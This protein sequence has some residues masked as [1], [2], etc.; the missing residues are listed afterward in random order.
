MISSL[1]PRRD[2]AVSVPVAAVL[3]A[4]AAGAL[5]ALAACGGSEEG[6]GKGPAGPAGNG[7]AGPAGKGSGPGGAMPPLPVT[8]QKMEPQRVPIVLEAVGQAE[9]S[10]EVEVRARVSGILEKRAY[11]EGTPVKEG[12]VLFVIDRAPYDIAVAQAKAAVAEARARQDIARREAERLKSLI[13]SKAISQR[14]YDQ[15]AAALDQTSAAVEAAQAKLAEAQL[16]LSYT[17]V[18]APISGITGRAVRS[19][20][21]L[22]AANTESSLLTTLSQVNP[23]WV[24]FSLSEAEHDRLRSAGKRAQVKL[25]T[26]DGGVAAQDGRLNFTA[27]TVDPRLGTVQL[28]AEFANPDLRWMPGQFV[29]VRVLVGEQQGYLVPQVAVL[30][31]EQGHAVWVVGPDA[32]A[33]PRPIKTAGWLGNQWIVVGGL[34]PGDT[35]IVDNLMKIRPGAPVQPLAPGQAPPTAPGQSAP[36]QSAPAPAAK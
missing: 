19:E 20:G 4:L 12:E 23:L 17:T 34:N 10:R 31:A 27:S 11:A 24:R 33:T 30:Q 9:G 29:R 35:V 36:G 2:F 32:K 21:S 5:L 8:V 18:K 15:A 7:A 26:P 1:P 16:N 28:R 3:R 14:E 22:V 13:Q 6:T 25:L